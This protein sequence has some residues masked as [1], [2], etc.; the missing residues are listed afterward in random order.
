MDENSHMNAV[1]QVM[2]NITLV[3]F[4]PKN[5][6]AENNDTPKKRNTYGL[7]RTVFMRRIGMSM[8]KTKNSDYITKKTKKSLSNSIKGRAEKGYR[9]ED[10]QNLL[11]HVLMNDAE[12]GK[13]VRLKIDKSPRTTLEIP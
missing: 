7:N 13:P 1:T 4:Q 12:H 10:A 6:E 2:P 3:R 11:Q 5:R 8:N 9:F